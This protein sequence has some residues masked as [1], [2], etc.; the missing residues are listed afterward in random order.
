MGE[1]GQTVRAAP[2]PVLPH[3][4]AHLRAFVMVPLVDVAPQWCHP[5]LRLRAVDLLAQL[6]EQDVRPL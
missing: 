3:P 2:D 5:V 1:D 4:R 6:P